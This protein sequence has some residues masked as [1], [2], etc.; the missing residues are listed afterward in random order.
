STRTVTSPSMRFAASKSASPTCWPPSPFSITIAL[1]LATMMSSIACPRERACPRK[2]RGL[3]PRTRRSGRRESRHRLL[4][5]RQVDGGRHEAEQDREPP[6]RIV[7]SCAL[8]YHAAQPHAEEAADLV[9]Q[10]GEAEQHGDPARSEHHRHQAGC[11]RHGRE[12]KQS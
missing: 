8:E 6:D 10:E 7:G 5:D 9:A 4:H 2:S 3:P 11:R 12:P 1:K